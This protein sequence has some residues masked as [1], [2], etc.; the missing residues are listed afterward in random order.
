ML[1]DTKSRRY[2]IPVLIHLLDILELLQ[3]TDAP[4]KMY[5]ISDATGVS[6][7]TTYR[8][9]R[10]L[11]YRGYLAQDREGKFRILDR[12]ELTSPSQPASGPSS[13][14]GPSGEQAAEIFHG[15]L[16]TLK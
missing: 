4:L 8:I 14:T 11:V 15:V 1:K 10:T 2:L 7:T 13:E 12:P 5:E 6:L 9:L 3:R 16:Q